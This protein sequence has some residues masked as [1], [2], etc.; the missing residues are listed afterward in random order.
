VSPGAPSETLKV[1][2][3]LL[4]G[5]GL[6]VSIFPENKTKQKQMLTIYLRRGRPAVTKALQDCDVR[7]AGGVWIAPD[8]RPSGAVF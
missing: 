6:A 3:D 5:A 2:P 1:P 7:G 4:T 8:L